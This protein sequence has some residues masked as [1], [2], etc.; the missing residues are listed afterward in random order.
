MR[1][2]GSSHLVT[3]YQRTQRRLS[4]HFRAAKNETA[5]RLESAF[6]SRFRLR[7]DRL[8]EAGQR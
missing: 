6:R 7:S 5:R 8:R 1:S 4:M 2:A 3:F